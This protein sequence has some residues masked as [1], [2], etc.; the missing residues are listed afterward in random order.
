MQATLE[1]RSSLLLRFCCSASQLSLS[2]EAGA[3]TLKRS[4]G[5]MACRV[6]TEAISLR[7]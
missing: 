3:S 4:L 5:G 1:A 2:G 6:E 7:S